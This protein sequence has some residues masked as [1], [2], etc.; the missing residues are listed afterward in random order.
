MGIVPGWHSTVFAPYFVSGAIFSGLALLCNLLITLRW[1][2]RLDR[3]ITL[4]HNDKLGR[5]LVLM[6]LLMSF[7]YASEFF[8]VW[9]AGEP[10]ELASFHYRAFGDYAPLFWLMLA[11]NCLFP[12]LLSRGGLR[13]N[14]AVL[15]VVAALINV[16]MYLERLI[17]VGVSLTRDFDPYTWRVYHP[18]IYE[19][20]ILAASIG[21]FT[22]LLLLFLRFCP[23]V[24][25]YEVKE[26]FHHEAA[27]LESGAREAGH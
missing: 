23:A 9:Y 26:V 8:S 10:I 22:F 13:R 21:L 11:C 1:A 2:F 19:W 14:N 4:E 5:L 18:T 24:P 25:M 3:Y 7:C 15:F 6:S 20:G 16:G 27:H 12:L 17:I